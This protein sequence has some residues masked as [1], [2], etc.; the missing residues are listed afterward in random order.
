MWLG[1]IDRIGAEPIG[2]IKFLLFLHSF[3]HIFEGEDA[4]AS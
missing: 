2:S 4:D 3:L 1:D